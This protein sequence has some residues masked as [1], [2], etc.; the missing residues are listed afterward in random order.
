M[1]IIPE[2]YKADKEAEGFTAA[3]PFC[4]PGLQPCAAYTLVTPRTPSPP[5]RV[6]EKFS[7]WRISREVRRTG[8][9]R[10]TR[11]R[12]GGR[13]TPNEMKTEYN[14]LKADADKI[15]TNT[16]LPL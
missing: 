3:T 9:Y 14:K 6:Q 2:N 15:K 13:Q 1:I 12:R 11:G 4:M 5:T 16:L 8:L 10:E 7:R